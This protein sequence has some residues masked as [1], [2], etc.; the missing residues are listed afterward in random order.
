MERAIRELQEHRRTRTTTVGGGGINPLQ[1][2]VFLKITPTANLV[3]ENSDIMLLF[4]V[5]CPSGFSHDDDKYM[6]SMMQ[7]WLERGRGRI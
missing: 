1:V 4:Y 5:D 6:V 7:V 2:C 3:T